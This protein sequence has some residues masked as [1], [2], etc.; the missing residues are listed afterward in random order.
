MK[1]SSKLWMKKWSFS[2]HCFFPLT[3]HCPDILLWKWTLQVFILVSNFDKYEIQKIPFSYPNNSSLDSNC[4]EMHKIQNDH[5]TFK[6]FGA[7]YQIQRPFHIPVVVSILSQVFKIRP[8]P[9]LGLYIWNKQTAT[10]FVRLGQPI[11]FLVFFGS[12]VCKVTH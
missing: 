11:C 7:K 12:L 6:Y 9:Y 1:L 8:R 10:A 3:S 4:H 2:F 5:I